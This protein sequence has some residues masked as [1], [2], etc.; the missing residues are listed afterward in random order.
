M[1]TMIFMPKKNN[2]S[3]DDIAG[4]VEDGIVGAVSNIIW[5]VIFGVF[6]GVI[7]IAGI[8]LYQNY[9]FNKAHPEFAK[10]AGRHTSTSGTV[11]FSI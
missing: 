4:A 10:H 3:R 2:L 6:I 5:N 1:G 9:T 7:I 11:L 8:V